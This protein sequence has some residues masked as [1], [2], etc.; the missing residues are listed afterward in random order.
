MTTTDTTAAGF[1]VTVPD[2]ATG[3]PNVI[4]LHPGIHAYVEKWSNHADPAQRLPQVL[5][6]I[7]EPGSRYL[8]P[9][10]HTRDEKVRVIRGKIRDANGEYGP[11]TVIRAKKGT[12]HTPES[13][14]G[15][16]LRVT[17][18]DVP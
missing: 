9:D 1:H 7:F 14:D 6:V 3:D 13:V 2:D 11:G 5:H 12:Q 16:W 17:F 18:T 15:A 8:K 10:I 4:E